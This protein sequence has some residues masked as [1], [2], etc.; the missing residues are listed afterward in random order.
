MLFDLKYTK[1]DEK[2]LR[3]VQGH[4]PTTEYGYTSIDLNFLAQI[5]FYAPSFEKNEYSISHSRN[6]SSSTA[7]VSS[8]DLKAGITIQKKTPFETSEGP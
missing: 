1:V 2:I 6:A 5:H 8:R 4:N 3:I 7:N